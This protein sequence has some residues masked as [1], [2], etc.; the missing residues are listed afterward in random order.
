LEIPAHLDWSLQKRKDS[1]RQSSMRVMQKIASTLFSGFIFRPFLVFIIPGM[2]L[3]LIS[4][5][6]IA[7]TLIHTI[8]YYERISVAQPHLSF[9]FA[10]SEAVAEAFKL[11][12]HSFLVGGFALIFALQLISLGILAM[13]S[14]RYFEDIFH[15][16]TTIYRHNREKGDE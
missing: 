11:S 2:A 1:G 7:W 4:L 3:L 6:P 9:G 5:Y 8:R 12:P 15:L 10:L 14:K 16:G 13:Q